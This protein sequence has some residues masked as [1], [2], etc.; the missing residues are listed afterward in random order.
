MPGFLFHD[1]IFGPV[2]SRRLGLSLG[3]NLLPSHSKYCSFNCIYCECGWTPE[4]G[5][6]VPD[7]PSRDIVSEYL[8]YRLKELIEEDHIPN[9]M[10]FAGNGE[11]T[12][13]PDF[14]GIV[15]D[16][17]ALRDKYMPGVKVSILS[18]ASMLSDSSIFNALL[19]LDNNIQKLDAG[20]ERLF[21][22]INNPVRSVKFDNLIT[23]LKKFNG[24]VIIQSMFLRGSYKGEVID[25]TTEAEVAGWLQH[26]DFIRPSLVMIYPISR[27]TPV[28]NLEKISIFE[29]EKI[30]EKVRKFGIEAKV[31]S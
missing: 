8:E 22:R 5:N 9:V 4:T 7:L 10:T 28:H 13:H 6:L 23:N 19:K 26:I 18:N 25:N 29:L 12:M 21:H 11:P 16:T 20:S 27:I 1:V 14:S 2:R 15:D 31:Y 24:K 3:I 30:A 17:L